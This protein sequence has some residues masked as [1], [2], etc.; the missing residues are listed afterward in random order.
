MVPGAKASIMRVGYIGG[1]VPD[2]ERFKMHKIGGAGDNE[3]LFRFCSPS[4]TLLSLGTGLTVGTPVD[5][6]TFR[7]QI[8]FSHGEHSFSLVE[9]GRKISTTPLLLA[10]RVDEV[11]L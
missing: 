6:S 2:V 7:A 3:R 10:E 1:I 5:F 9:S 4:F 8:A 11:K